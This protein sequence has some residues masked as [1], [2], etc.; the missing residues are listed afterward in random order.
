L[1]SK[2]NLLSAGLEAILFAADS[3]VAVGKFIRALE[4]FPRTEVEAAL[5]QLQERYQQDDHGIELLEIA[6]GWQLL[7]RR[8]FAAAVERALG[9]RTRSRSRLSNAGL[10]TLAIIAYR[11]PVTR[12]EVEVVRGVDCAGT[13][14]GLADHG[15]I[16]VVGRADTP[17]KP[18]L[19]GTTDDFLSHFGLRHLGDLPNPEDHEDQQLLAIQVKIA[20]D[21]PAGSGK[22]T[23][24]RLV[25]SRLGLYYVDTGAIYRALTHRALAKKIDLDDPAALVELVRRTKLEFEKTEHTARLLIEGNAVGAE[26]RTPEVTQTIKQLADLPPI[27]DIVNATVRRL[28][29]TLPGGVVVEG[30]DTGSLLFPKTEYKFYLSASVSERATR[31]LGEYK[32]RGES[33]SLPDLEERILERDKADTTR[34]YGALVKLSDATEIDTTGMS[35][36]E[37]VEAVVSRVK[38][39]QQ[40]E[41]T[42]EAVAE[43]TPAE[44]SKDEEA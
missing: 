37:V 23:I 26:I 20:I 43:E 25:A 15:L 22:S 3:P 6:G 32:A 30:R 40:P 42:A 24:A 21:G 1:P 14:A 36:Q 35:I 28:A 9:G 13:L 11:Q 17:G 12:G 16:T 39:I 29:E 10:E 2:E 44:E 31:R 19:Y 27:R 34:P 18:H 38:E 5:R 8:N 7:T 33:I 4:Q 41:E